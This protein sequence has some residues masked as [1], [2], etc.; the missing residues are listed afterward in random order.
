MGGFFMPKIMKKEKYR[1]IFDMDGTLYQLDKGRSRQFTASR[2]YADLKGYVYD[3]FMAKQNITR[4]LAIKEY[5]RIINIYQGEVSL[6]VEAEYGIDRYEF[7]AGTWGKL[8]PAIYIETDEALPAIFSGLS[9]K[10]ALLTS[11]PG[12]WATKVLAYLNLQ[13]IFGSAIYTGE[14]DVRKPN[15]LIFQQIIDTFKVR[16]SRVFSIG[17]QEASDIIPARAVGL[18]TLR[19]GLDETCADYQAKD[20]FTAINLLKRRGFL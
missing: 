4:N 1:F 12:V 19:I 16:P 14:P 6:G 18:R 9:G 17:D 13:E 10:I 8:N 15:P 3:F 20:I 11:A 2:F 5:E 7:F